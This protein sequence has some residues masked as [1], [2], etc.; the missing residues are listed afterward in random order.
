LGERLQT[1][2]SPV[3]KPDAGQAHFFLHASAEKQRK[4][5]VTLT[6]HDFVNNSVFQMPR[7]FLL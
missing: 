4:D 1:S 5:V 6:A 7:T 3:L 2:G